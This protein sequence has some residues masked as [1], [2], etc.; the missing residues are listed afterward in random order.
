MSETED[1]NFELE[2]WIPWFC[3]LDDHHFFCEVDI[4]FIQD[5]FN[6]HGL[7]KKFNQFDEA[8]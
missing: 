3:N 8:I 1:E 4:Q 2:G 6:L 7:K 5:R